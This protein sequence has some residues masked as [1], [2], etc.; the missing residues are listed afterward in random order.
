VGYRTGGAATSAGSTTTRWLAG[1]AACP[2]SAGRCAA[3]TRHGAD[4]AQYSAPAALRAGPARYITDSTGDDATTA[5][6]YGT[7]TGAAGNRPD[8]L[9]ADH[10]NTTRYD[11]DSAGRHTH[12]PG[13]TL[14][15]VV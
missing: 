6:R 2:S 14:L 10:A 5:G 8:S 1:T 4:P 12:V 13:S 3:A 11:A 15:A 9:T 7:T